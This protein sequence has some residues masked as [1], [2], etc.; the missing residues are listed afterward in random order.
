M[1][2]NTIII[3]CVTSL[4]APT[5]LKLWRYDVTSDGAMSAIS[6]T[7]IYGHDHNKLT[8]AMKYQKY[9]RA[10]LTG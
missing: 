1:E 8:K 6:T 2:Q 10:T 5:N 9:S 4:Q 3:A 7:L